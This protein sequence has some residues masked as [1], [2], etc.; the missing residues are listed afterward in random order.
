MIHNRIT[1]VLV[2]YQKK[3][4]Q[5]GSMALLKQLSSDPEFSLLIYDNSPTKQKDSFLEEANVTYIHDPKNPGLAEAYNAALQSAI[6]KNSQLL[7]LA[8]QDTVLTLDYLRALQKE[9][10]TANIGAW[11]PIVYSHDR[12]ISPVFADTY[13][14]S[15]SE[16]PT[17]GISQRRV[18]AINSGA[19]VSVAVLQT[20]GGFN[21]AFSLDFLDHW[22]FWM[23]NK[24]GYQIKILPDELLH[25]LSVLDYRQVSVSRYESILA[26]ER[27]FYQEYDVEKLAAHKRQ[28]LLRTIKQFLTVS[29]RQIWRKTLAE[30][31]KI[32][33]YVR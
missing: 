14:N 16:Y 32:R 21:E 3:L 8:D 9:T 30:Y 10:L 28:L 29:N 23:L 22:L 4:D 7:L 33:K 1:I 25:D 15:A 26:A 12:Q 31:R 17:F 5:V 13:I 19:A 18:M 11:V 27:L 2:L 6:E 24:S 20:I